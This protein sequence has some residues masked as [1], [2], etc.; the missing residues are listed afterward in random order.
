MTTKVTPF[1]VNYGYHLRIGFK[2]IREEWVE[3]INDF[4]TQIKQVHEETQIAMM[5]TQDMIKQH[6]DQNR[7]ETPIYRIG[8]KIMISNQNYNINRP[9]W[10]LA[11]KLMGPFCKG[12]YKMCQPTSKP[13]CQ[14]GA[15]SS[16]A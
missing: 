2:L 15:M 1:Y 16:S 6:A 9:S 3:D 7:G 12:N 8:D 11:E 5:Q 14:K 4:M 10:K 13:L